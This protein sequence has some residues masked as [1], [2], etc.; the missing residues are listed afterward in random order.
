MS[1]KRVEYAHIRVTHPLTLPYF[2]LRDTRIT[3]LKMSHLLYLTLLLQNLQLDVQL[4]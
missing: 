2:F 1:I 3:S 4:L